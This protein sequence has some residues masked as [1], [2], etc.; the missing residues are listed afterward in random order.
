MSHLKDFSFYPNTNGQPLE[1][2][3]LS[4]TGLS[5]FGVSLGCDRARISTRARLRGGQGLGSELMGAQTR[6]WGEGREMWVE[7]GCSDGLAIR[8]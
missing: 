4:V 2:F 1:G 7:S 8:R 3:K 6:T 5:L